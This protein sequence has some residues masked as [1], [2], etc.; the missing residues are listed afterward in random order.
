MDLYS[1]YPKFEDVDGNHP[2]KMRIYSQDQLYIFIAIIHVQLEIS[3]LCKCA[4]VMIYFRPV[5]G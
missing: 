1:K 5:Y 3:L 2:G 4:Y